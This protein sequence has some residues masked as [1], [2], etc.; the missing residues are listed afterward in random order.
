M[1]IALIQYNPTIGDF[2]NNLNKMKRMLKIAKDKG[3]DL[4]IFPEMATC[5]YPPKDLL[6]H[7]DFIDANLKVLGELVEYTKPT[8]LITGFVDYNPHGAPG[9]PLVNAGLFFDGKS[10]RVIFTKSLLPSYDVFDE[11]RY[12]EPATEVKVVEFNGLRI[13]LTI[14]EDIWNDEDFFPSPIYEK[15]PVQELAQVGCDLLINISASPFYIGKYSFKKRL[16]TGLAK[17]YGFALLYVNQIGGNDDLLFDGASMASDKDGIIRAQAKEFEEDIVIYDTEKNKGDMH[18]LEASDESTVLKGLIT[19]TRDYITKCGFKKAII[20]LSGGIDSSLVASIATKALGSENV[21]G[22]AMPSPYTS[23]ESIEDAEILARNLKIQFFTIPITNIFHAYLKEL[24]PIFE[25]MK[26][27]VTEE[28]IQARIRG[29]ILMALSNKLGA[30]VLSTGNKSE[31]AVGY[32]TLY[33]DMSGGLAV[34]SD[35]PKTMVYRLGRLINAEKELIPE[36]VFKKAP[37]AE[38]RPDQKDEDS[39]PPYELLDPI[40]DRIVVRQQPVKDIV[41]DG[42]PKEVVERVWKMIFNNEYKRQQAPPGLKVTS[43][44]FGS[45]RRYPIAKGDYLS[46]FKSS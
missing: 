29:N 4:I 17:K 37:S 11:T 28:N 35:V 45:G 43:K 7:R 15:N 10:K 13:G 34:I 44:A 41:K 14:C 24:R 1:R 30:L 22:V 19:G 9:K 5:G 16:V 21:I 42:F 40:L 25:G 12:F 33:G 23:R 46:I 8:A 2:N 38:L 3:A 32:C 31:L 20:G 26:E 6:E 18:S 27:D 39:L 36:R